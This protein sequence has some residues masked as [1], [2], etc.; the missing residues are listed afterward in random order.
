V[1]QLGT[2]LLTNDGCRPNSLQVFNKSSRVTSVTHSQTTPHK[3]H[4][5]HDATDTV[6]KPLWQEH[7]DYVTDAS[8][9]VSCFMLEWL[10]VI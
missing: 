4:K 2:E 6:T 7:K 8:R 5:H 3:H 1:R 9:N 10:H